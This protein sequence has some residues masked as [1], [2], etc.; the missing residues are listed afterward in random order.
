MSEPASSTPKARP[1]HLWTV[2]VLTL[3]WDG[4]GAYTI[5]MA[6]AGNLPNLSPEEL[7][8]Y[9]AQ[10]LWLVIFTDISLLGAIA[11]GIALL[12]KSRFAVHLFALSLTTI[13]ITNIYELAAGS[14]QVYNNT[15]ALVV[16]CIIVLLAILQLVY[17][18]AMK[19][20][21]VLA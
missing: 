9:A 14:S 21:E 2:G 10:P 6:Q 3:L 11:A 17:A 12:L 20:R 5:M 16:T 19:K 7:A 13:F 8:Y 18:L 1:W 4:S 15:G